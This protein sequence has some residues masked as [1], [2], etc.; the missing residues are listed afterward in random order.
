MAF[1]DTIGKVFHIPAVGK[2]REK[3][4][5]IMRGF[6]DLAVFL[7]R[8]TAFQYK[9]YIT[10]IEAM[11]KVLESVAQKIRNGEEIKTFEEFFDLWIDVSERKFFEVFR[12]EEFSLMQGEL[13]DSSLN[14]RRHF[15]KLMELYLFDL[16][17]ALRSEMDDLYRTVYDL[18]KKVR[19]LEKQLNAATGKETVT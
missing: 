17:V 9:I 14:V 4:E 12:T 15:Q 11:E 18:K 5:L 13:L 6:D 1:D 3:V 10:G 16:P 8:N 2:D 7:A 19:N